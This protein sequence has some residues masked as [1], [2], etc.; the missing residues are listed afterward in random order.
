MKNVKR[1]GAVYAACLAYFSLLISW[2]RFADPDAY[3]HAKFSAL[4]WS[5]GPFRSFP[6][7]DLTAFN[8]MFAD[9][10]FLFHVFESPFVHA[11]G[12]HNGARIVAVLLAA[13]CI[14]S[15]YGALRW[16][17][18][19]HPALWTILLAVTPPFAMRL[20]LGKASPLVIGFFI[21]GLTAAWKKRP[22]ILAAL[23]F[24]FALSHG[25]WVYLV[26]SVVLLAFG[27]ALFHGVVENKRPSWSVLREP[28]AAILGALAGLLIHP[29][30]RNIF[31]FL[32][33]QVVQVGLGTPHGA[34]FLGN[35]WSPGDASLLVPWF[36]LWL[37]V[38][39]LG[40]G[41]MVLW[42]KKE[43][44]RESMAASIA[45]AFPVSV[46]VALTFK[47][48][49]SAEY[50]APS[51][52]LWLPWMWSMVDVR[53]MRKGLFPRGWKS[54]STVPLVLFVIMFVYGIGGAY[55]ALHGA[56]YPD[57][58]YRDAMVPISERL[59]PGD[60]I[61]HSDWDEFPMLWSIEDRAAY[62]SGVDPTYLY[63]ASSTLSDQYFD[64][65]RR[66]TTEISIEE[67]WSII[68]DTF[69]AR[70]VFIDKKDHSDLMEAILR[71]SR[72]HLLHETDRAVSFEV[73]P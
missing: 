67:T 63:E 54:F 39:L 6:W 17:R 71:D 33:L 62:I 32:W 22:F 14:T 70:F 13:F 34:V 57:D 64:L 51:L 15:F 28:A 20:S 25:G 69:R 24:L 37:V 46:L 48:R 43:V 47:S 7:L 3:Y 4:L 60:R 27:E 11:F 72:Y 73:I 66:R 30:S 18:V 55:S 41:G 1:L 56:I 23:A 59:E 5:P 45:F 65:T 38:F 26:G 40:I 42:R 31:S 35:E 68:H 52:G 16:L 53:R 58:V 29:N 50:L 61:F 49:R 10:H 12:L 2:D 8:P 36:A 9:L 44:S 19:S 21:L